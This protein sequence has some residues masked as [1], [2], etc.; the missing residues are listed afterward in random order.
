MLAAR[1][2][3][4]ILD[5]VRRTGAVRVSE[6]TQS[7]GVSDMTI[8]RDLDGL[9]R[10][11]LLEKVYGG[12]TATS[13]FEPGFETKSRQEQGEKRAIAREA[14]SLVEPGTAVGLSAGTTTWA[15]AHELRSIPRLTVV[16][17]SI[18]V[19]SVFHAAPEQREQTVVLTGGIRTLSG[20]LVGPVA[21]RSLSDLNLDVVFLGVHGMAAGAGFTTPNLMEADTNRA[22]ATA[23]RRR[24]VV[25][26]GTKWGTIGVATFARLEEADV[27]VT[28]NGLPDEA[29]RVLGEL[30]GELIVAGEDPLAETS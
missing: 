4:L 6:L 29:R 13:T 2:R 11:G 8:R 19:A 21:V 20:A 1:R 26:D 9:A 24:V 7:L 14:S 22:L 15:L 28:D 17:N 5:M 30:V 25:A 12:A 10:Q 18:E 23:G 16:T 3:E 27:L